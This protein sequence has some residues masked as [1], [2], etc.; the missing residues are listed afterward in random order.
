[1]AHETVCCVAGRCGAAAP[2]T[3]DDGEKLPGLAA[4]AGRATA[5]LAL[6]GRLAGH[7]VAGLLSGAPPH[8]RHYDDDAGDDDADADDDENASDA[9]EGNDDGGGADG[10]DDDD[11]D[12]D[13]VCFV[14]RL[15]GSA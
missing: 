8:G 9:A 3:H 6:G 11:L 10:L 1:M 2:V 4:G 5:P 12:V 14:F 15:P 13:E 7:G